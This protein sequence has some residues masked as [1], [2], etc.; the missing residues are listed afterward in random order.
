MNGTKIYCTAPF[1]V[2]SPGSDRGAGCLRSLVAGS[3]GGVAGGCG[4]SQVTP[5]HGTIPRARAGDH[6]TRLPG[7]V[8]PVPKLET[9]H[10]CA[11]RPA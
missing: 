1:G 6:T 5:R 8:P 7:G 11:T 2:L 4:T 3:G 10:A 9:L